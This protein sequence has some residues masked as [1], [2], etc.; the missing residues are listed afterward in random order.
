V[1]RD[2]AELQRRGLVE[3]TAEGVRARKELILAFLPWR[4]RG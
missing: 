4:K 2:V 1:Y 3:R